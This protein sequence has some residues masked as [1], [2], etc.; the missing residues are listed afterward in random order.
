[1]LTCTMRDEPGETIGSLYTHFCDLYDVWW[2]GSPC[3]QSSF[4]AQIKCV[5][6]VSR[7]RVKGM[8]IDR[9]QCVVACDVMSK[10]RC[11]MPLNCIVPEH[12]IVPCPDDWDVRS[13]SVMLSFAR[14]GEAFVY[15]ASVHM[16]PPASAGL[17]WRTIET[18]SARQ[19]VVRP[20]YKIE[21]PAP[22]QTRDDAKIEA[23]APRQTRD[24]AK[25]DMGYV[26]MMIDEQARS[27]SSVLVK[28]GM[29]GPSQTPQ[30]RLVSLRTGNPHLMLGMS[31]MVAQPKAVEQRVHASILDLADPV[32]CQGSREFFRLKPHVT[33]YQLTERVLKT[34]FAHRL[35]IMDIVR[36]AQ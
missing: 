24:D 31:T 26:Y 11:L 15:F 19:A 32:E 9:N 21:A 29:T 23:P 25:I 6:S 12:K 16:D 27:D 17:V 7:G 5:F 33:L 13:C 10:G 8:V 28:I 1:M 34:T 36:S 20:L 4:E 18:E 35:N 30:D 3:S 14:R 2:D 22:R